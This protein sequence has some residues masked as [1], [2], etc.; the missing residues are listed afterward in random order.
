MTERLVLT[1]GCSLSNLP[2]F[3]AEG[4]GIFAE[5]GLT[6]EAPAYT[7][8][9]S[10][11]E[12]LSTGAADLG[13]AAFTQPLI[14]S[15]RPN[16]PIMVAG[17]GLMGIA[18]LVQ[19]GIDGG[20]ALAGR[21]VGTFRGDPLEV[22]LHDVLAAAGL[23]MDDVDLHY[24]DDIAAAMDLFATGKLAAITLAEPHAT[25][26]RALGA[27]DLSDG[28][29]LWG[30]SFPDT[31]LVASAAM[32]AERPAV[33]QAAVRAM[34]QAERLIASDP[35]A[36]IRWALPQFPGYGTAELAEAAG[37]QPPCVDIRRFVATMLDRW[38]ALQSL[39]LAP[40][41]LPA[42]TSAIALDL[43]AA[44]LGPTHAPTNAP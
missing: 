21:P 3:V 42:P 38:P 43:L 27:S 26:L 10:T 2:L 37:R 31:V 19:P 30:S 29:E 17:S 6:V 15:V 20:A 18:V 4:A 23:R 36:A 8:M 40:S 33:V 34:L 7:R 11:A 32:L 16:P 14:D 25:R 13:T 12:A 35:V 24:L 22:L 41:G 9:S 44:E 5:H 28:T 1:H 39:G